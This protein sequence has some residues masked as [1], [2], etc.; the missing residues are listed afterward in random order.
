MWEHQPLQELWPT[1]G[2]RKKCLDDDDAPGST[3]T[4]A[5]SQ[6][7]GADLKEGGMISDRE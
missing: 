7:G 4:L 1:L 5:V 3:G 2:K 6:S